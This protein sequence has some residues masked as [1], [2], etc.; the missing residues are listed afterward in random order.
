MKLLVLGGT[1]FVGRHLVA[2]ALA[3]GHE[4]TLFHRGQRGAELF[5]EVERITGD[6]TAGLDALRGQRW[7]AVVDT[8]GYAARDVRASA[9]LLADAAERYAFVSTVS[10]YADLAHRPLDES[11]PLHPPDAES[12]EVEP[13]RY[14]G[15]KVACEQA[16]ESAF[17]GRALVARPGLVVGP[18]DYTCR[19]PYWVNRIAAGGEVLAPGDPERPVQLVDARDLGGWIVRKLEDGTTGTFNVA[20]PAHRLTMR[21]LLEGV[22]DGVGGDVRFTWVPDAFL[23]EQDVGEWSEMPLWVTGESAGILEMDSGR[24]VAAGLTFRPVAETA[25]DTRRA[26][27]ERTGEDERKGGLAPEKEAAVLAAWHAR[28][29]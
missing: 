21:A 18:H 9:T 14:G 25:R 24:A 11:A 2:E 17:P 19:F 23:A 22:R 26:E 3:R 15:M 13:A 12:T 1:R 16:V 7:D 8:A 28:A 5:P 4:V 10:V 6:R 27:V 20:G 29:G